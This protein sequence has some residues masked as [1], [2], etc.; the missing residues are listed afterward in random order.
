MARRGAATTASTSSDEHDSVGVVGVNMGNNNG[1]EAADE[2][3]EAAAEG[4]GGGGGSSEGGAM[5]DG[6]GGSGSGGKAA[7]GTL[8]WLAVQSVCTVSVF[9]TLLGYDIG[10]M[11]G[12]LLPLSRD[13]RFTAGQDEV[14]VV[15]LVYKWAVYKLNPVADP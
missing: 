6:S 9:A 5:T 3:E 7:G 10:V 2:M 13:L 12:A 14:A 1:A 11:S 15:G 8:E 4:G